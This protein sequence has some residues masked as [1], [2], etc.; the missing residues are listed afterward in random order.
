MRQWYTNSLKYVYATKGLRLE[1]PYAVSP[2]PNTCGTCTMGSR[3]KKTQGACATET[4][5]GG[6]SISSLDSDT[7]A[8]LVN[9]IRSTADPNGLNPDV[10]D[11][12]VTSNSGTCKKNSAMGVKI[13]VDGVCYENIHP[14]EHTVFDYTYWAVAHDGNDNAASAKRAN[15][16][17][18]F[19]QLGVTTLHFPGCAILA[20][21]LS[22]QHT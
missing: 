14:D 3:W 11:I 7:K 22:E 10:R 2:C 19:A 1:T 17:K 8:T 6:N 18:N 12:I 5:L 15:P 9:V 21:H 20:T 13:T 16:I 4:S